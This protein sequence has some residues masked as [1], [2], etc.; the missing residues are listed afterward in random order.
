MNTSYETTH[1]LSSLTCLSILLSSSASPS[2]FDR[3][4]R[5]RLELRS[6]GVF[7]LRRL[8]FSFYKSLQGKIKKEQDVPQFKI[9]FGRVAFITGKSGEQL[10]YVHTHTLLPSHSM[11]CRAL[12]TDRWKTFS[13]CSSQAA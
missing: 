12:E 11:L 10:L 13:H 6:F 1:C 7:P 8:F 5:P 2:L 4:R 9:N 3:S